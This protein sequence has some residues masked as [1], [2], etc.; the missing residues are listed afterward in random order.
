MLGLFP[1]DPHEICRPGLE[2]YFGQNHITINTSAKIEGWN[3][4]EFVFGL[5]TY[6]FYV[7]LS[8]IFR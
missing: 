2:T 4:K 8:N 5:E 3:L 6:G 7:F 1:C